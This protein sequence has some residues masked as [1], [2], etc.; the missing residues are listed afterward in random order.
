M[1]C[2]PALRKPA[3][4]QVMLSQH[5]FDQIVPDMHNSGDCAATAIAKFAQ[6]VGARALS[7]AKG[8]R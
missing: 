8:A 7:A 3:R 2:G 6:F 4:P 5:K 1:T